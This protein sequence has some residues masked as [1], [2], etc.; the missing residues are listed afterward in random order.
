MKGSDMKNQNIDRLSTE[1]RNI[2][3]AVFDYDLPASCGLPAD[4]IEIKIDGDVYNLT[5]GHGCVTFHALGDTEKYIRHRGD[6][7]WAIAYRGDGIGN[8]TDGKQW[9]ID[10]GM[11]EGLFNEGKR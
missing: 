6:D 5:A 10:H 11:K 1:A 8:A 9:L 7:E 4:A 3:Q 2:I